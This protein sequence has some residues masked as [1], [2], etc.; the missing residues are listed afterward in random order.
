MDRT[1]VS[2]R[3]TVVIRP[4]HSCGR[5]TAAPQDPAHKRRPAHFHRPCSLGLRTLYI[6]F[7]LWSRIASPTAVYFL[8]QLPYY[9]CA[10]AMCYARV[11]L[12]PWGT[13]TGNA[14]G[15]VIRT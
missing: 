1:I 15:N 12:N 4:L 7:L 14:M 11:W 2:S 8:L 13:P 9:E 5:A 10:R 6:R 3:S